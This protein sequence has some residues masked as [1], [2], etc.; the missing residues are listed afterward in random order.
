MGFFKR[1]KQAKEGV[2][3]V[4]GEVEHYT[5][6]ADQLKAKT[7]RDLGMDLDAVMRQ[8]MDAMAGGGQ[9]ELMAQA[10]RASRLFQVGVETPAVLHSFEL[11]EPS[12]LQGGV[13]AHLELTVQ[14]PAGAPY[15]V[16]TDQVMHESMASTLAADQHVTVRVDPDDSQSVL[17]WATAPAA[18]T[19]PAPT[20]GPAERIAKLEGL[21]VSGV[22]TDAEFE[23]QKAKLLGLA[24]GDTE[25]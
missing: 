8:G 2:T 18:A 14:P 23:E 4:R 15:Q 22:L 13:P 7:G 9:Q 12:P 21:R 10:A 1:Q 5:D 24:D 25:L 17:L 16:S 3:E 20:A 19:A 6:L 11:G